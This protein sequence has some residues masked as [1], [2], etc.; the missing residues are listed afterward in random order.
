MEEMRDR[1][2]GMARACANARLSLSLSLSLSSLFPNL[3]PFKE[4]QI[5]YLAAP[6][7]A[8]VAVGAVKLCRCI[9]NCAAK[10]VN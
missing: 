10:A 3:E 6:G 7:A 2:G 1:T 4:A 5:F 8:Q 9:V